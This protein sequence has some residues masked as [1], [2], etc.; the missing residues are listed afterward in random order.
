MIL[1]KHMKLL[2]NYSNHCMTNCP[3]KKY[4]RKQNYIDSPWIK[5]A[6]KR[7]LKKNK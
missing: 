5:G 3:M 1:T 4:S 7:L 6:T 2:K